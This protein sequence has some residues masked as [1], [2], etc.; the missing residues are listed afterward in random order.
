MEGASGRESRSFLT[1]GRGKRFWSFEAPGHRVRGGR[2]GAS[3]VGSF[4]LGPRSK[5]PLRGSAA[6]AALSRPPGAEE[7]DRAERSWMGVVKRLFTWGRIAARWSDAV[8]R[9]IQG[10]SPRR[11][12]RRRS[13]RRKLRARES[14]GFSGAR[15]VGRLQK[16]VQRHL[17]REVEGSR[18]ANQD[19]AR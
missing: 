14:G 16:S 9:C 3:E 8:L 6:I 12:D 19:S 4:R 17:A 7:Q 11:A 13:L 18:E 5:T 15:V 2:Q 10:V 1:K